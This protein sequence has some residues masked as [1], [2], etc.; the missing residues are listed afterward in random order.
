MTT[1]YPEGRRCQSWATW[2]NYIA[3]ERKRTTAKV[4]QNQLNDV[5]QNHQNTEE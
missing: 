3:A 1:I 4:A 5:F 2:R